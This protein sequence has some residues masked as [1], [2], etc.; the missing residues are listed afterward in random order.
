MQRL[1]PQSISENILAVPAP[2]TTKCDFCQVSFCGIGIPTRCVAAPLLMQHPHGLSDISDLIQCREVYDC[3]D[4]NT[5]EVDIMLDYLTAQRL[6][7][8][9]IYREVRPLL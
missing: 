9:H 4:S 6:T 7:P 1:T 5:V 3:F 2:T 8:R